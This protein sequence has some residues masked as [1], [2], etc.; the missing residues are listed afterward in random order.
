MA[1]GSGTR[2]TPPGLAA[3][4]AV[5]AATGALLYPLFMRLVP[6]WDLLV[7]LAGGRSVAA[8]HD[9]YPALGSPALYDGHQFVYPYLTALP[10][11]G[12]DQLPAG[13]IFPL[14]Y[15]AS[16]TAIGLA[17]ALLRPDRPVVVLFVLT[18]SVTV[19]GLQVG[20]VNPFLLLA[21]AL[22][23]RFRHRTWVLAGAVGAAVELKVFLLP[24][25]AWLLLARRYRAAVAATG[26]AGL[27]AGAGFLAGPLG[28]AGYL[29]LL[30]QLSA[31]E[32]GHGSSLV[33]VL[34]GY[35]LGPQPATA[36]AVLAG[37]V[38]LAA[39]W[40]GGRRG[41]D[42]RLVFG[43]AL[44]VCLMLS[45][46]VWAHYYLLLA[47]PPVLVAAEPVGVA[48][49]FMAATWLVARP[50]LITLNHPQHVVVGVLGTVLLLAGAA[51]EMI[52]FP[53]GGWRRIVAAGGVL[54]FA[55]AL[56]MPGNGNLPPLAGMVAVLV[57]L[58][59]RA[60]L[61]GPVDDAGVEAPPGLS[62]DLRKLAR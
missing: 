17:C 49:V 28:P 22:A 40:W 19:I 16:V 10:F 33:A 51:V 30:D 62:P 55:A 3:A 46:I 14:Y 58:W 35:G 2:T 31:H 42:E 39:A 26:V 60:S 4:P 48:A 57:F 15:A 37:A 34:R 50:H 29:R 11:A 20:T 6:P 36:V 38:L 1:T 52:S 59:S 8:G 21:V 12:L 24:L 32:S 45:P 23:W 13:L 47:V 25:L 53:A 56:L 41:G 44:V 27:L 43:T 7:F 9:P 54:A 5:A 61:R 18:A